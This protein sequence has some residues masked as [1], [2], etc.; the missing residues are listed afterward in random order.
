M[1][2]HHVAIV[3]AGFS[4]LGLAIRLRQ[5]RFDDFVVFERGDD[6]GGT[7]RDNT[8]PGAAC[9]VPS[10]L[11]SY[12]F[13]PNPDWTRSFSPQAEI[14]AYL[15]RCAERSGVLP[16]VRLGQEVLAATWEE[17][18]QHWVVDTTSGRCTARVLVSARGPLSE[19]RLPDVP[20]LST[21]TGHLFHSARWDH[22]HDLRGERVA[23]IGTGASAV[24]FVPELQ[25]LA[26]RLTVFQRTAPWVLPRRD[27]ALRPVERRLF[28]AFPPAQRLARAAVYWG[29]ELF[30]LG[31]VG[32]RW[33]RRALSCA[34]MAAARRQLARQ[35][36]DPTLRALLTPRYE[37]G[38][39]RVV[40]SNDW[41]PALCAPNV[42][43]VA[44]PVSE[45]RP[46]S[47]VT[48]SGTEHPV[49]TI[50]LGTGF[51][52][53]GS[54]GAATV[55]GCGGRTLAEA[56]SEGLAAHRSTT[57]SG[58]PNLFLMVGPNAGLGHTS[59]VF[60]IESQIAYVLGAL[61]A[62]EQRGATSLEVRP[63]AQAAWNRRLAERSRHTVWTAG[64]CRSYYL[65]E[66][67]RN[68]AVWPGSSWGLRNALR[69]FDAE[70]YRFADGPSTSPVRHA[71]DAPRTAQPA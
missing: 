54:A 10:V 6:V 47:V 65:D 8:Y 22:D 60:V 43:V 61:A 59:I 53:T 35:V 68:V 45:V 62:L 48:A 44:E 2:D 36:A 41:Y 23:V 25:P 24:Q 12:S 34:A 37:L 40:L 7:W 16:H 27:R 69:R 51:D 46:R 3:G 31:F 15:R 28:R 29:R 66:R 71:A 19:P 5:R 67:G 18:A 49:D 32:P 4:G 17:A 38:C 20:G 58:F 57:V 1:T 50:V 14:Q 70:S 52:V 56:W 63:E 55:T 26:R 13:A 39:K 9:D 21:F 42:D 64:G 33:R 30:V 11:Y